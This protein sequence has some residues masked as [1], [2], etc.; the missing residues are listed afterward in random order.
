MA[1]D[2]AERWE[3][4]PYEELDQAE[5]THSTRAVGPVVVLGHSY[6]HPILPHDSLTISHRPEQVST[7]TQDTTVTVAQA[8]PLWRCEGA[9]AHRVSAFRYGQLP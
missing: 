3:A 8:G 7:W 2:D 9:L 5:D 1:D 4:L 6:V